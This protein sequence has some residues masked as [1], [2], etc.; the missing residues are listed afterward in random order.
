MNECK[1]CA[2]YK[3]RAVVVESKDKRQ[4]WRMEVEDKQNEETENWTSSW[5]EYDPLLIAAWDIRHR[6]G[7]GD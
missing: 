5:A 4:R 1:V 6:P 3:R 2:E 7:T